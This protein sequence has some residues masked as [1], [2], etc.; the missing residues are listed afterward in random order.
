MGQDKVKKAQRQMAT[1]K[2][3]KVSRQKEIAQ[4]EAGYKTE[5]RKMDDNKPGNAIVAAPVDQTLFLP[6][7]QSDSASRLQSQPRTQS[8]AI[9]E[10]VVRKAKRQATAGRVT[11]TG[12]LT[13]EGGV[14][15]FDRYIENNADSTGELKNEVPAGGEVELSFDVDD[16]GLAQHITVTKPLCK[17]CDAEAIRLLKD[18]PKWKGKENNGKVKIKFQ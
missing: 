7:P 4:T 11:I 16:E 12:N 15:S 14:E 3:G 6:V 9:E 10:V 1:A 18:G 13:P 5:A 17:K 2:T 8:A